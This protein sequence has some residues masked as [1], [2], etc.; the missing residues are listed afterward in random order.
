MTWTRHQFLR[1][2]GSA[3]AAVVVTGDRGPAFAHA[4]KPITVSHSVSTVVYA[5]H[6][7]AKDKDDDNGMKVW[8][9]LAVEQ[10]IP[11]ARAVD[12]SFVKKARAKYK[13]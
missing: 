13:S 11:N 6:L 8:L 10:P 5:R 9:P 3:G 7:A 2:A 4:A 1:A 12:V